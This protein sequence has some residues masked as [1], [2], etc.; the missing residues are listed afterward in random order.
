MDY[1]TKMFINFATIR[2][3][4]VKSFHSK[5]HTSFSTDTSKEIKACR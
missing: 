2:C 1:Q 4:K 3:I 5:N